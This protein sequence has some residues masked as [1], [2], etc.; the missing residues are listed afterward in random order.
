MWKA[1]VNGKPTPSPE[2][3][4][5]AIE[6]IPDK[7]YFP[8]HWYDLRDFRIL[9]ALACL[10]GCVDCESFIVM[11]RQRPRTEDGLRQDVTCLV[12]TEVVAVRISRICEPRAVDL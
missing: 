8:V 7:Q 4:A 11:G 5:K 2:A 12:S 9:A 1:K 6:H 10:R 3:F